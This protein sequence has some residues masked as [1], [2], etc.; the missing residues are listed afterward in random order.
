MVLPEV[1]ISRVDH[2]R[3]IT[4]VELWDELLVVTEDVHA[5]FPAV[6]HTVKDAIL[7]TSESVHLKLN[8]VRGEL[9]DQVVKDCAHGRVMAQV[10][11]GLIT[12][13]LFILFMTLVW[14]IDI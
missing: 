13:Q 6:V 12:W 14:Q 2:E 3:A 4:H 10:H 8:Q 1:C 11:V 7:G 5:V 9:S